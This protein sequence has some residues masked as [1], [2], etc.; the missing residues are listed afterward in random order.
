MGFAEWIGGWRQVRHIGGYSYQLSR[1][2]R[3]RIVRE[4]GFK[5]YGER[6]EHWLLTGRWSEEEI[7]GQFGHYIERVRPLGELIRR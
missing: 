7:R 4:Q 1:L 5:H 6:D 3:R 2:G